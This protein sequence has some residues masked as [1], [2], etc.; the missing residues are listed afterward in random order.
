MSSSGADG[1]RWRVHLVWLAL[2]AGIASL[3]HLMIP[4]IW[5]ADTAYHLSVARY[6]RESGILHA[7]PWTSASWLAEHYAD[8][9]L[10]FHLLMVPIANF[11]PLWVSRIVGITLAVCLLGSFYSIATKEKVE[12]PGVWVLIL[13][14][15][16]AAFILRL[17]AVRPH[18]ISIPLSLW[19]VWACHRK[20][21]GVLGVLSFLFPLSYTAWHLPMIL[22]CIVEGVRCLSGVSWRGG[23]GMVRSLSLPRPV[24]EWRG[25]VAVTVAT[26]AGVLVHPNFPA[27]L[28]LFWIQNFRILFEV[29][30]A[31]KSGF[32]LGG[33]FEAFELA[34]FL[35]FALIPSAFLGVALVSSW[36]DRQ[37]DGLALAFATS[38]LAFGLLTLGSQRFIEYLAPFAVLALALV[39]HRLRP[40]AL[41]T[42]ALALCPVFLLLF[43]RA[44]L[45]SLLRR[46]DEL[47]PA[48][49]QHLRATIPENEQVVS[50]DWGMTGSLMLALHDRR[51][52]VALDPVFFWIASPERYRLWYRAMHRPPEGVGSLLRDTFDARYVLCDRRPVWQPVFEAL[53]RDPEARLVSADGLWFVYELLPPGQEVERET[54]AQTR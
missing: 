2:F 18:L 7:F 52:L 47:P 30:W 45:E 50:C 31:A 36:R 22:V 21:W 32:D 53:A 10:L 34:D 15:C 4:A 38:G 27:N 28:E 14:S 26:S 54:V 19:I 33:E 16:S 17:V 24:F 9:E 44:P 13:L 25:V 37:R 8:K 12:E 42:T 3:L 35:R 46:G 49:A 43:A 40:F 5:D 23:R 11:E 20:R 41:R 6:T 39:A 1:G 48:M 29:S 51:F